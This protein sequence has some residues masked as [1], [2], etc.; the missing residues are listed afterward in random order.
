MLKS[1][2]VDVV[3]SGTVADVSVDKAAVFSISSVT[4]ANLTHSASLSRYGKASIGR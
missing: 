2:K 1:L 3:V 4:V